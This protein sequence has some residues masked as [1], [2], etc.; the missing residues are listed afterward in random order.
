MHA[1]SLQL[2]LTLCDPMDCSPPGSSVCGSLQARILEWVATPFSR[3]SSQPRDRNCLECLMS[4]ALAGGFFTTS[5]TWE[6]Q[7]SLTAVSLIEQSTDDTQSFKNNKNMK[8]STP[9]KTI[10][11]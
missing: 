5:A 11:T 4:P 8:A 9:L 7:D 10:W 1:K 6:A 2:C 3:G